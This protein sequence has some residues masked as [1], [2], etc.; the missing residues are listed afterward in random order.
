[1]EVEVVEGEGDG[2]EEELDRWLG[3]LFGITKRGEKE[4]Q[5]AYSAENGVEDGPWVNRKGGI[6]PVED[7]AEFHGHGVEPV[8]PLIVESSSLVITKAR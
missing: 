5:F 7:V 4:L 6:L 2:V 3:R 1:V 8:E